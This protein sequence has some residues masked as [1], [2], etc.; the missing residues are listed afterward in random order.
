MVSCM[1][2]TIRSAPAVADVAASL[3]S[4]EPSTRPRLDNLAW[5]DGLLHGGQIALCDHHIQV[6]VISD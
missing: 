4:S 3:L 2:A 6:G 1:A 5:F